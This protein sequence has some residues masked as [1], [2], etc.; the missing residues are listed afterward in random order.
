MFKLQ[1]LEIT[2]F[3]SFADHT[4]LVFTG[5]G[6][7]A[8]VGPNGCGKSNVADAIAW[9]L[10]EQRVKHLRG[11]DMKDVIFQGSRNRPP[12][13]MAEVV[14]H[15]IRSETVEHEPDIEDI[16]STLEELDERAVTF[17]EVEGQASPDEQ[18]LE[19]ADATIAE[20]V[21]EALIRSCGRT[22]PLLP[23]HKQ[24]RVFM[25]SGIG[26]QEVRWCWSSLLANLCR[27]REGSIALA[28]ASI[29]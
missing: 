4:E 10:G 1:R 18:V 14:L 11:A 28:K 6:I 29:C 23:T 7:T 8:V 27:L 21:V 2:G 22:H 5:D 15:L 16:D 17:D 9:V 26:G 12:S 13:G 25:A 24:A 20:P 3:K 19:T